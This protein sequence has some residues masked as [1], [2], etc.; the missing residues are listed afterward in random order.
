MLHAGLVVLMSIS[1]SC[2]SISEYPTTG[3]CYFLGVYTKEKF[4]FVSI[5]KRQGINALFLDTRNLWML[6]SLL[7]NQW[8]QIDFEN[9]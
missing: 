4:D 2:F 7:R 8:S 1:F 9:N 5:R 3:W 6:A